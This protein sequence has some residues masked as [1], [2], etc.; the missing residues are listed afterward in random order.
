MLLWLDYGFIFIGFTLF[1]SNYKVIAEIWKTV[2]PIILLFF[3]LVNFSKSDNVSSDPNVVI[4]DRSEGKT[5]RIWSNCNYALKAWEWHWA[6]ALAWLWLARD[7]CHLKKAVPQ[8]TDSSLLHS[9][10][11]MNSYSVWLDECRALRTVICLCFW[12]SCWE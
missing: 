8:M 6:S 11:H 5:V 7:R 3:S 12:L 1:S 9:D 4:C 2:R 10:I